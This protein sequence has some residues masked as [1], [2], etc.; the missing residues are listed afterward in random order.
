MTDDELIEAF[1][2]CTLDAFPHELH[3]RTAWCYLRRD[4]ILIAL[5]R[6]RA[7]LRRFAASKGES[8]RYHETITVAYMLLIAERLGGARGLSWDAFAQRNAD[9]LERTPSPLAAFYSPGILA[10]DRA[11]HTFVMPEPEA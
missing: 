9:L 10:S 2:A 3:V 8:G 11:R 6:F 7:D 1:E 5:P 4:P